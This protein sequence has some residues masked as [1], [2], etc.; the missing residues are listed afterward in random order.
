MST[1]E[2]S[3]KLSLLIVEDD[4][5]IS[6]ALHAVVEKAFDCRTLEVANDGQQAWDILQNQTFDLILSDWNM[7]GLTGQELLEKIRKSD[8]H[9]KTPFLMLTARA[10]KDSVVGAIQAG[11]ND[12]ISKPYQKDQLVEKINKLLSLSKQRDSSIDDLAMVN[13]SNGE[14]SPRDIVKYVLKRFKDGKVELPVLPHVYNSVNEVMDGDD[15]SVNDIIKIIE[16]EPAISAAL[17][18]ISNSTFY[19]GTST[20]KTLDQAVTRIGLKATRHYI[21]MI[22]GRFLFKSDNKNFTDIMNKLW[23][24]SLATSICARALSEQLKLGDKDVIFSMGLL[25]DIGKLPLVNLLIE[26]S[27]KRD[28]ITEDV[29]SSVFDTLHTEIGAIMLTQWH[30]PEEIIN[31]VKY[32]HDLSDKKLHTNELLI[33]HL[34]NILVRTLGFSLKPD[35]GIEVEEIESAKLLNIDKSSLE[36][37]LISVKE[38]IEGI[39][40]QL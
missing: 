24:H 26:L 37:V 13:D 30:F 33:V 35:E 11:A 25:H 6:L 20:N 15:Y 21:F 31:I 7:P 40:K 8:E 18:T 5:Y 19:R 23:D 29:I 22:E 16:T 4:E 9:R 38:G 2:N 32:H 27:E 12:Y 34:A 36:E 39:K 17:I 1:D 28:D 10:D 3:T 14:D